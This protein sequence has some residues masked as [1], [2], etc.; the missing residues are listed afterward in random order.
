MKKKIIL[1]V[2]CGDVNGIGIEV[3]LKA[4]SKKTLFNICV[5]V[6]FVPKKI[7][8]FYNTTQR[9]KNI[10]YNIISSICEAVPLKIN[11][12]DLKHKNN[13]FIDY[14]CAQ[15]TAE[16]ALNSFNVS[17]DALKKNKML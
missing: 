14:E 1:G 3:F 6:L 7:L 4:F 8:E 9:L 15:N 5:P 16:I 17:I 2:S 13:N 12:L 11:L 10:K